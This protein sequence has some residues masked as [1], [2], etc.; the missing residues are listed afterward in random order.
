MSR[1]KPQLAP[2]L[3]APFRER[4]LKDGNVYDN[5]NRSKFNTEEKEALKN[6][7]PELTFPQVTDFAKNAYADHPGEAAFRK[8]IGVQ[9]SSENVS[10]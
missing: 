8:Y 3:L 7:Y 9:A 10:D 1:T 2:I 5:D 4:F 6:K